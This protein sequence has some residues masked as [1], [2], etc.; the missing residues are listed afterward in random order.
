MSQFYIFLLA[1]GI[2]KLFS[3]FHNSPKN[4]TI[5]LK[6]LGKNQ[7]FYVFYWFKLSINQLST[8]DDL[9]E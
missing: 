5:N 2:N 9:L 1:N 6:F 7:N 4:H 3:D 8:Y